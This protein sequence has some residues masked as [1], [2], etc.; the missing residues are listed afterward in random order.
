[1]TTN[2][3]PE[4]AVWFPAVRAGSGTDVF[5]ER[6]AVELSKRG[7]RAEIT[8]LPLRAEYASWSVARPEPPGWANVVHI[9]TWLHPRF[10][11]GD[12]PVIATLHHSTHHPDLEPYKGFLRSVYHKHWIRPYELRTLQRADCVVAVSR[13]AADTA[14]ATLT[15]RPIPVVYNGV[16]TARFRP[17]GR[18]GMHRPFRL[19]YVGKWASLKGVNLLAPIMRALGEGFELRY[20]GVGASGKDQADKPTNMHDIGRLMGPDAVIA[21]MQDADALLFPSRSE[22]FPMV[23]IEALSCGLPVIASDVPSLA[24]AIQDGVT[25]YLVRKDDVEGFCA[26]CRTMS[27]DRVHL[28][29]MAESARKRIVDMFSVERMVENYLAVYRDVLARGAH[30]A[31]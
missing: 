17:L 3:R 16:D 30:A 20:T 24:E 21:A 29:G 6:L 26:A 28:E 13:Y 22:G 23:V 31:G 7:L 11:P 19:L 5:T 9:N 14:R 27:R 4:P 8:W 1:M 12:L 18:P 15:D 2:T 25:G 10:L